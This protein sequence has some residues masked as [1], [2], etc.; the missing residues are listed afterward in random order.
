VRHRRDTRKRHFPQRAR[1]ATVK[2]MKKILILAVLVGL[3]AFA[4]KKLKG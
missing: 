2:G 4:A 3:S 1:F